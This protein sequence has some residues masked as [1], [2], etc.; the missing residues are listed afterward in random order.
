MDLSEK[1]TDNLHL[2]M[3]VI[4][5]L[6]IAMQIIAILSHVLIKF[7]LYLSEKKEEYLVNTQK[8]EID[9]LLKKYK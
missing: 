8:D 4:I 1:I 3:K 5:C 7:K 6:F 9:E 2:V